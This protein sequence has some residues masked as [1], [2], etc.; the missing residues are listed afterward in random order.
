MRLFLARSLGLCPACFV[1]LFPLTSPLELLLPHPGRTFGLLDPPPLPLRP[2]FLLLLTLE[3][4]LLLTLGTFGPCRFAALALHGQIAVPFLGA[5]GAFRG[6]SF[7]ALLRGE[8]S[9][10]GTRFGLLLC[11]RPWVRFAP[12]PRGR[13]LFRRRRGRG[14]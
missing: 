3:L 6:R 10:P 1:H 12:G 5:T 7:L 2:L 11:G 9:L 8:L 13:S 4:E 14:G